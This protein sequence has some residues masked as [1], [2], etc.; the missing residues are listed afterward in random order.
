MNSLGC[1]YDEGLYGLSRDGNKALE[2]YHRAG[3]LGS[4]KAYYNIGY[5]Y[6]NGRGVERDEKNMLHYYELAA[7]GGD[8]IS[9]HNH[10]YIEMM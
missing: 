8:A 10:G 4:A 9:R 5:A 3:E 2:L 6:Y 1:F 7:M